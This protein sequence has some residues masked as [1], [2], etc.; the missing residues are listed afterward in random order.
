M[1]ETMSAFVIRELKGR[2]RIIFFVSPMVRWFKLV[3]IN[4]VIK[5]WSFYNVFKCFWSCTFM[6][7][8]L[9]CK[10]GTLHK[11]LGIVHSC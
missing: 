5:L 8:S 4:I 1:G 2:K 10:R 9:M 11:N 6:F 7:V 3:A